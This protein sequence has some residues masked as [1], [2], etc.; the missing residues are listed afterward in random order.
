MCPSKDAVHVPTLHHERLD[1]KG[2][3]AEMPTIWFA[4]LVTLAVTSGACATP[5]K[6]DIVVAKAAVDKAVAAKANEYAPQSLTAALEAQAK[7]DAELKVQ[8]GHLPMM[9][10]YSDAMKLAEV[11]TAAGKKAEEDAAKTEQLA[12]AEA[13]TGRRCKSCHSGRRSAA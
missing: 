2:A 6:T 11:V 8:D 4:V 13:S 3:V 10:S 1:L 12:R 9:R 5:P 7:L